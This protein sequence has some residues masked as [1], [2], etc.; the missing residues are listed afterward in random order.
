[1]TPQYALAHVFFPNLIKSKGVATVVGVIERKEKFFFDVVWGQAH[2]E[3]APYLTSQ[4]RDAYRIGVVSLPAPKEMG[5]AYFIGLVVKNGD[6]QFARY[7]MLEH[8][9]V[10]ATQTTRTIL[11][12]RE[13]TKHTKRGDGPA[14]TGNNEVDAAAF[15]DAFMALIVP[16]SKK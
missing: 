10:L 14:L 13:G 3:H 7:F 2:V 16:T 12:E 15:L 9:F 1:M 8:D 6:P 4:L 5:E 11:S